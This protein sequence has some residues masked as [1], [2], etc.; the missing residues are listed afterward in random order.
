MLLRASSNSLAT[1]FHVDSST[2]PSLSI[3]N[4]FPQSKLIDST[5][6]KIKFFPLFYPNRPNRRLESSFSSSSRLTKDTKTKVEPTTIFQEKQETRPW[7]R[8]IRFG[9]ALGQGCCSF[10]SVSTCFSL[11]TGCYRRLFI[12]PSLVKPVPSQTKKTNFSMF[13]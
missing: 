8:E 2:S 7:G 12:G 11:S 6:R 3:P 13:H 1:R 5:R 9:M 10:F 4:Q